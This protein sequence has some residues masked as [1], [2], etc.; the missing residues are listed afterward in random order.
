[1][2]I[3]LMIVRAIYLQLYCCITVLLVLL[4]HLFLGDT[5]GDLHCYICYNLH[6]SGIYVTLL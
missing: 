6:C 2:P 3:L 4:L 5:Y 1:M